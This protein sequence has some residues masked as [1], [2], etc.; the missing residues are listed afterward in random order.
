MSYDCY[1]KCLSKYLGKII[2]NLE[3][4]H[5][6]IRANTSPNAIVANII[7]QIYIIMNYNLVFK[8]NYYK[9]WQ[10]PYTLPVLNLL[11]KKTRLF[12]LEYFQDLFYNC[13]N[14]GPKLKKKQPLKVYHLATLEENID[15]Q[16]LPTSYSE[17]TLMLKDFNSN[18]NTKKEEKEETLEEIEEILDISSKLETKMSQIIF[19]SKTEIEGDQKALERLKEG[20]SGSSPVWLPSRYGQLEDLNEV[21]S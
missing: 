21:G 4:T 13:R 15:L 19:C 10:Y 16:Y 11:D 8:N 12:L 14:S 1:S 3:N 7:K 17:G 9:T 2:E 20:V 5:S 18:E 6:Q